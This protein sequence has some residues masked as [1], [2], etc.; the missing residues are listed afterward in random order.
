M[1]VVVVDEKYRIVLPREVR[2]KLN[3][4]KGDRVL[5][6]PVPEGALLI[7]VGR[8]QFA[9]YLK[10]FVYEEELHEATR[11]VLERRRKRCRSSTQ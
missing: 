3:I 6:V 8:D 11:Y 5:I 2:S 4:R 9:G 1:S 10:D 7:T